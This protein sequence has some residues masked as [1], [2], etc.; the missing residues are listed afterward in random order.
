MTSIYLSYA[1]DNSDAVMP[2]AEAL[3]A[4]GVII[5]HDKHNLYTGKQW[6]KRLFDAIAEQEYFLLFWSK[7][8]AASNLVELE[9]RT[10]LAVNKPFFL[11][12]L[13]ATPLPVK[14]LAVPVLPSDLFAILQA[15][16]NKA[17]TT[18]PP[19]NKA[20][21]KIFTDITATQPDKVLRA[22]KAAFKQYQDIQ[23]S[24]R[25]QADIDGIPIYRSTEKPADFTKIRWS[26]WLFGIAL[27]AGVLIIV[28]A[29]AD[30]SKLPEQWTRLWTFRND[31]MPI[32]TELA[33]SGTVHDK[34]NIPLAEVNIVLPELN[35]QTTTNQY[36]EFSIRVE[37]SEQHKTR[38]LAQKSGYQPYE[39]QI[40]PGSRVH[41]YLERM[42][43]RYDRP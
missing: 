23:Q 32:A 16:R 2:L 11:C 12:N 34:D 9:W 30:L 37:N 24:I 43:Y 10:A 4:T 3:T 21:A 5:W 13:D 38:L 28:L 22:V 35:Q 39:T 14:L 27:L 26:Q 6:P 29:F 8:A 36:G 42:R 33:I 41:F 20:I 25:N 15:L 40:I 1:L 19:R 18:D 17:P 31:L 7:E